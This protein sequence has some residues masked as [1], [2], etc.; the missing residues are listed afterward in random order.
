MLSQFLLDSIVKSD[1]SLSSGF[2]D[3]N[4][5]E[6]DSIVKSDSS[7]SSGFVDPNYNELDSI[8]KSDSSLSKK[9]IIRF[10]SLIV[11]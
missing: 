4:Y 1:S 5:N 6:L 11:L 3:P 7:L 9:K 2:V 8:V 10:I